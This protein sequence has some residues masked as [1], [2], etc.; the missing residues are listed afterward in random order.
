MYFEHFGLN[1]PP[2]KI[3]PNQEFYY[4]GGSRADILNKLVYAITCNDGLLIK[5][6]GEPGTGKTMLAHM[7][8]ISLPPELQV[9]KIPSPALRE[10][11][12]PWIVADAMGLNLGKLPYERAVLV[13]QQH[14][15]RR[16]S[17]GRKVS[18]F[19]DE[20]QTLTAGVLEELYRL[21]SPGN[22]SFKLV[23]VV[24]FGQPELDVL[25]NQPQLR[26][27][28]EQITHN[29]L[30]THL[31]KTEVGD[32]LLFRLRVA[33]YR[34]PQVFSKNALKQVYNASGGSIRRINILADKALLAAFLDNTHLVGSEQIEV[35]LRESWF[36]P[37]KSGYLP[38]KSYLILLLGSVLL[39]MILWLLK[40]QTASAPATPPTI[41]VAPVTVA[42]ISPVAVVAG[43]ERK[44]EPSLRA[45]QEPLPAAVAP[46]ATMP[47]LPQPNSKTQGDTLVPATQK[48]K[49]S[50]GGEPENAGKKKA[51]AERILPAQTPQSTPPMTENSLQ[52]RLDKSSEW[53]RKQDD[54]LYTVQLAITSP[55]LA[56]A[57]IQ[58]IH[59][60]S[61]LK[62]EMVAAYRTIADGKP[63]INIVS[64]VY[65]SMREA[66]EAVASLPPQLLEYSP[67]I[68]TFK[69]I[70]TE[71]SR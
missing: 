41:A 49:P 24:L 55:E 31:N 67:L 15:A 18:L 50:G 47:D 64:G 51:G 58:R 46:T 69:G 16:Q 10:K 4:S 42:P 33:G 44:V 34:G 30:L 1:Q 37:V 8:E 56:L 19:V 39:T 53:L 43:N 9:V 68:R 32:Y 35:A 61:P 28:R 48:R 25:I 54:S 20:S 5:I 36:E 14:L 13:L 63:M 52:S 17:Q 23:Q 65:P 7:L 22:V 29:F 26:N 60:K 62:A 40:W 45:L 57:E 38:K 21:A 3:V 66:R 70:R 27:F 6:V 71:L 11:G 12:I 2:F 59:A